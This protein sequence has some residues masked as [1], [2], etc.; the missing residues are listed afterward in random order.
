MLQCVILF[1]SFPTK[2]QK[3]Q[4]CVV[5]CLFIC[6]CVLSTLGNNT[7]CAG[8]LAATWNACCTIPKRSTQCFLL[9]CCR[10]CCHCA[11]A[12]QVH[13]AA[14]EFACMLTRL[15]VVSRAV[16]A[17]LFLCFRRWLPACFGLCVRFV[18]AT[19][20]PPTGT[21]DAFWSQCL[22]FE[23]ARCIARYLGLDNCG[24]FCYIIWY[25]CESCCFR[26]HDNNSKIQT[27]V[28]LWL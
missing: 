28:W 9:H 4:P 22:I 18:T 5:V 24:D 1:T 17:F 21:L 3:D 27:A 16:L 14:A 12:L 6:C 25:C 15:S 10:M 8:I 13:L 2:Q 23:Y 26:W 20:A 19:E 11:G 7:M